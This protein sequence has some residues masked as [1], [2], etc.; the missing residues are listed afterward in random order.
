[1]R[2]RF[3]LRRLARLPSV[4]ARRLLAPIDGEGGWARLERAQQALAQQMARQEAALKQVE[5]RL[6][7]LEQRLAGQQAVFMHAGLDRLDRL[8]LL[9]GRVAARQLAHLPRLRSLAD[10]EFRVS[11]QW[12]EDGIIEWL[13]G[14]LPGIPPTF[15]EFGVE[16][17]AESNTRFLLTNRGWRGLIIDGDA[18]AMRSLRDDAMYWRHDLTAVGAFITRENIADLLADHD[19]HRGLGILSIDI[20]GNDYWV[21]EALGEVQP[22]VLICEVNGVFGD[23]H[24][25]TIPYRPDFRRLEAHFSG[26]YFGCSIK[27]VASLARKQGY[28]FL[29]TNS[30]GVNAFFVRDDL[31]PPVL[32]SLEEAH[33]WAPR[34]RD[35][36]DL[37]GRLSFAGG[38][39]R[40][41]LIADLPVV[42]LTTGSVVPLMELGPLYSRTFMAE[43]EDT[44]WTNSSGLPSRSGN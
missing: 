40:P 13:C 23:L 19:F 11:S 14:K 36:R 44:A 6:L 17:Y 42:E 32:G 7:A 22:A 2:T 5:P 39:T 10:A 4:A 30:N 16:N 12:G 35:S 9:Q 3:S 41:A 31:A 34:H 29:G 38:L 21:L 28:T 18:A 24:A 33:I 43:I 27:A 20:D 25:I 26:Q 1:M 8:L 37:E 15:V